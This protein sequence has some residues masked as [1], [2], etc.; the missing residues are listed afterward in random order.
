MADLSEGYR[1]GHW[2]DH[3][4]LTGGNAFGLAAE[5]GCA[6]VHT[7]T[8]REIPEGSVGAGTGATAL[9]IRRA[10]KLAQRS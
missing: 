2:S 7:A 3:A 10:F 6:A 4:A 1:V 9:S 5:A 8:P